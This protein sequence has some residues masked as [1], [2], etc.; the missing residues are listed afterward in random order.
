[1]ID[2]FL[3][4]STKPSQGVVTAIP[5]HSQFIQFTYIVDEWM[6]GIANG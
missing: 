5:R 6:D 3:T 1:M 2:F 4:Y